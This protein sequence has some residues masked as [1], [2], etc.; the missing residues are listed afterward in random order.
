MRGGGG[1]T[2]SGDKGYDML[3]MNPRG[4]PSLMSPKA[5]IGLPVPM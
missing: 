1:V 5:H 4:R 2:L 3:P